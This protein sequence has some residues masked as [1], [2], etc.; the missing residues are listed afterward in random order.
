MLLLCCEAFGIFK[1]FP[2]AED[3]DENIAACPGLTWIR[4]VR[5]G[6]VFFFCSGCFSLSLHAVHAAE[7]ETSNI[8]WYVWFGH[9]S[10]EVRTNYLFLSMFLFLLSSQKWKSSAGTEAL[11]HFENSFLP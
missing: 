4:C 7:D 11:F 5:N 8:D 10:V 1:G 9:W 2:H 6:T 3:Y